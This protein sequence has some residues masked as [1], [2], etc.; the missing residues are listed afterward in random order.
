[1]SPG[2]DLLTC[3]FNNKL[4]SYSFGNCKDT[5]TLKVKLISLRLKKVLLHLTP[6]FFQHRN[7]SVNKWENNVMCV[8]YLKK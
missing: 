3:F 6:K 8:A 5:F 4:K 2:L 7:R 1:M